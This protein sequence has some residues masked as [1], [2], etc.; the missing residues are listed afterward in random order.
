MHSLPSNKHKPQQVLSKSP[1]DASNFVFGLVLPATKFPSFTS[2]KALLTDRGGV[3]SSGAI[4]GIQHNLVTVVN[5]GL[6]VAMP[7]CHHTM[8]QPV[9]QLRVAVYTLSIKCMLGHTVALDPSLDT[10][11]EL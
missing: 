2:N 4:E 5:L 9:G 8:L 7:G 6:N 10:P 1:V 11:T 3:S